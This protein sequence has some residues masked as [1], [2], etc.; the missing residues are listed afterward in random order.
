MKSSFIWAVLP[1]LWYMQFP[2][3]FLAVN[4]FLTSI[5]A[6][7]AVYMSRKYKY[8][9][10]VI[11]I[12][13]AII[14]NIGFFVPKDWLNITDAD[15]FSGIS[16]QKQMTISI[17][18]YLPI[19]ATLPP[20]NEAPSVP[21]VMDGKAEFFDYVKGSDFQSGKVKVIEDATIQIPLFDF[22]GM[23]VKVDGKKVSHYNNDCRGKD[24]CYGLITFKLVKGEYLIEVELTDTPIR[25]LGNFITLISILIL[26]WLTYLNAKNN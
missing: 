11:V 5:L 6:G 3:R 15:K 8:V 10:G 12:V 16:W 19:A 23:Q 24:F 7:F 4:I 17:F 9:L 1:P 22:P 25:K 18:D 13:A 26:V 20:I 14:L 21:D 2:W